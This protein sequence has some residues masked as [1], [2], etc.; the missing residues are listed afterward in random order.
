MKECTLLRKQ[1]DNVRVMLIRPG[2]HWTIGIMQILEIIVIEI[3][4]IRDGKTE[5]RKISNFILPF[6]LKLPPEDVA[7]HHIP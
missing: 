7:D 4:A 6:V 5:G 1:N 3:I 2:F